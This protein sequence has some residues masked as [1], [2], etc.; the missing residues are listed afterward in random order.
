MHISSINEKH[1][2]S[3][4]IGT[5]VL[6]WLFVLHSLAFRGYFETWYLWHIPAKQPPFIDFRLIPSGAETFRAGIDPAVSNPND[7]RQH[8]FNYP[9]IWYIFFH[10]GITQADTVWLCVLLIF[11]FFLIVFLFPEKILAVDALLML[12]IVFSPAAMLLYERGNLD[13]AFFILCGLSV[14]LLQR[15]PFWA[16]TLLMI[17][18]IFKF[19]PFFG[20]GIFLQE[21]RN[22]FY[23]YLF[24]SL[25]IFSIYVA[26]SFDSLMAA[27]KLTERGTVISYGVYVIFEILHAY[28]RYYLLKV[29][30]EAQVLVALKWLPYLVCLLYLGLIFLLSTVKKTSWVTPA[31]GNLTAFRMGVLIY[32]GTFFLGNNWDYRL[33]FLIFT[34][35][36]LS[37]WIFS[38]AGWQRWFVV[39]VFVSMLFSCWFMPLNQRIMFL[40]DHTYEFQMKI[41]DEIMNWTLLGGLTYLF[42]ATAPEWF[43]T[44]AWVRTPLRAEQ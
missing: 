18:A 40:Y 28:F 39:G 24:A 14:L 9:K 44:F 22:R 33:A 38:L 19:F 36:Q 3:V 35:P 32:A 43:R 12:L 23:K 37:R 4:L 34:V 42:V 15:S 16:A 7:P 26:L 31:Q 1:G 11:L 41:F 5:S 25:V 29:L 10:T 27:W 2:R 17:G 20:I 6:I 8:I 21:G 30:A 13:L